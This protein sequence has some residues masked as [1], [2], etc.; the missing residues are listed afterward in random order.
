MDRIGCILTVRRTSTYGL[1]DGGRAGMI[2]VYI[3]SFVGFF[4]AVISMAEISS[5][6]V[7]PYM[8]RFTF[9]IGSDFSPGHQHLLVNTTGSANLAPQER[10]GS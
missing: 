7:F 4:A 1:T 8:S 6:Y 2:Y 3:G 5:V 9:T 10:N